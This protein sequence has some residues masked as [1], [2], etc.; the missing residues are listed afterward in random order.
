MTQTGG[1]MA[2]ADW[3]PDPSQA[4]RLRYWDGARWTPHTA[5][6]PAPL[7]PQP[8]DPT[9]DRILAWSIA[10]FAVLIV[11]VFV[12]VAML[13]GSEPSVPDDGELAASYLGQ[14][15]TE[16]YAT[17]DGPPP[18][19]IESGAYYYIATASAGRVTTNTY[20]RDI[21]GTSRDDWC[22]W[23]TNRNGGQP[24]EFSAQDGVRKGA[25]GN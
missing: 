17:N 4:G 5:D 24:W 10:G 11:V 8:L 22:L 23:V 25:C 2:P 18:S 21:E 20:F 13:R 3:Y 16:W 6:R 12:A 9:T 7:G 14:A 19:I 1:P 15:V